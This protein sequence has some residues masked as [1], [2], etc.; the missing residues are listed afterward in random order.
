VGDDEDQVGRR[1][2]TRRVDLRRLD[3]VTL[4]ATLRRTHALEGE[5]FSSVEPFEQYRERLCSNDARSLVLW[6]FEAADGQLVGYNFVLLFQVAVDGRIVT[7][8]RSN[9]GLLPAWRRYNRI[10]GAG[11][12]PCLVERLRH[13]RRPIYLHLWLSHPSGYV[14]LDAYFDVVWPS[15]RNDPAPTGIERLVSAMNERFGAP[16]LAP[17]SG[18]PWIVCFPVRVSE[19]PETIE[20][21]RS[22]TRPSVRYYCER[23]PGFDRGHALTVLVPVTLGALIGIVLRLLTRRVL[24]RRWNRMT[25]S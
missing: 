18:D 2:R 10:V 3:A 25:T 24:G 14:M 16:A 22:S 23:N 5:I 15:L 17:P 12:R 6:T 11:L 4:E 20:R 19:A 1:P 7:V 8:L 21:W 9:A 13:P